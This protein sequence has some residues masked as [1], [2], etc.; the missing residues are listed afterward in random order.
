MKKQEAFDC[1]S[2]CVYCEFANSADEDA[3]TVYCRKRKKEVP[4]DGRCFRFRYDLL[5]HTPTLPPKF[6]FADLDL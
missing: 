1:P 3:E 6:N 2:I 4:C 5:K